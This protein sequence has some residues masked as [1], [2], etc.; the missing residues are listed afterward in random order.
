MRPI[1]CLIF[2]TILVVAVIGD[3]VSAHGGELQEV[4]FYVA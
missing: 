3:V 1:S 4:T 2:T